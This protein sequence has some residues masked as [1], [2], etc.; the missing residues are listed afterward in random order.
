MAIVEF[1]PK[2]SQ[3]TLDYQY[4]T[5]T[6]YKALAHFSAGGE[7]GV[8]FVPEKLSKAVTKGF[9]SRLGGEWWDSPRCF[10]YEKK[11]VG[12]VGYIEVVHEKWN[13][14]LRV[15]NLWVDPISRRAGIGGTLLRHAMKI[16]ANAGAR[17]VVLETQTCNVPAI[18]LY[19]AS[20]FVFTGC[21][22]TAYSNDD[23]GRDEV[24][25]E[26]VRIL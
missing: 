3:V 21:D 14:R 19:L 26:L 15:T 13:N 20:G 18:R 12:R 8:R 23:A 7:M 9:T 5:D 22:L 10:A 4:T 24:R 6:V 17:A 1:N 11:G 2:D 16:A 25:L